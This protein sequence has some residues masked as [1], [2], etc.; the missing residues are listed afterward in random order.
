MYSCTEVS[1]EVIALDSDGVGTLVHWLYH[2]RCCLRMVYLYR[3]HCCINVPPDMCRHAGRGG[4][5]VCT[6]LLQKL[7]FHWGAVPVRH[8][9]AHR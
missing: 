3:C 5:V 8:S 9:S 2:T 7:H 6:N 4:R 1:P